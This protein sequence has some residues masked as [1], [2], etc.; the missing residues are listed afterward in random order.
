M[1]QGVAVVV[2]KIVQTRVMDREGLVSASLLAV[3]PFFHKDDLAGDPVKDV[4]PNGFNT[5]VSTGGCG[6]WLVQRARMRPRR[7]VGGKG[8][9]A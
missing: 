1:R 9:R 4:M 8:G 2:R 5:H 3:G 7:V 6:V